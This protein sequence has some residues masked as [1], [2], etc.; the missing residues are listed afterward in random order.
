MI[1]VGNNY[2]VIEFYYT[3]TLCYLNKVVCLDI[4]QIG[5]LDAESHG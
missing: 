3:S 5:A 2:E 4:S 1:L